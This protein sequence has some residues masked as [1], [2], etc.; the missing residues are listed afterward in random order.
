MTTNIT[1]AR[2]AK[3]ASV[4]S[5]EKWVVIND[6]IMPPPRSFGRP[7]FDWNP[8]FDGTYWHES[9]ALKLIV[10]IAK[11]MN[12]IYCNECAYDYFVEMLASKNLEAIYKLALDLG[13]SDE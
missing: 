5:G 1:P 6:R 9:Q 4:V 13:W 7:S 8:S 3:I 10:W 2:I 11:Q 12:D